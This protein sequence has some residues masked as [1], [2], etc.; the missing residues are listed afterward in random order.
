MGNYNFSKPPLAEG[1]VV[2]I[3]HDKFTH[4]NEIPEKVLRVGDIGKVV[5][6]TNMLQSRPNARPITVS[7]VVFQDGKSDIY[8][9]NNLLAARK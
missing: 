7:K 3:V 8:L 9:T 2:K 4:D 1:T 6:T 5:Y